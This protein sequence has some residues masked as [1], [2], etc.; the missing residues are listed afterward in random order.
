MIWQNPAMVASFLT[1]NP[2]FFTI[3][4]VTTQEEK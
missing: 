1:G 3:Q 2:L 4:S